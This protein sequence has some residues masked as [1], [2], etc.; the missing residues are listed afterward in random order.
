M[1]LFLSSF[2]FALKSNP[3]LSNF[4]DVV[5]Q[6]RIGI[7]LAAYLEYIEAYLKF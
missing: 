1:V 3:S 4:R 6:T 7:L 2:S 5:L